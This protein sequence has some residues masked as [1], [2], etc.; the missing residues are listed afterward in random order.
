MPAR[1][2]LHAEPPPLPRRLT[3]PVPVVLVGSGIWLAV[4]VVLGVLALTGVR[5]LDVWFAAALV[6]V[7]LGAVG[8]LVLGLQ[9]RA[10]R[11]GVKGAQKL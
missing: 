5:P 3:D 10:V 1:F 7:A 2:D 4:A 11:R 6:G 8:L 9:R